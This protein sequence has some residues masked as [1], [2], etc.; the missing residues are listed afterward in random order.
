M[1]IL[2]IKKMVMK[3]KVIEGEVHHIYQKTIDGALIFYSLRDYLVFFTIYCTFAERLDVTVLA[4]CPMPDHLHSACR[5]ISEEQMI[6]FVQQYTRI[7]AK[8]WNRSRKRKGSLFQEHFGSAVK[9]GNKAVRTTLN[10][11]NNNP[12]ERKI[13]TKAEDYRWNFLKYFKNGNP[14]SKPLEESAA[15][16][17]L[18][19]ALNDVRTLHKK[20]DWV[21]YAQLDLWMKGLSPDEI[22][23]L[24]DYIITTWNIIDYAGA[25]CYYGNYD[26]MLRSLHDNTGGEYDIREDSDNYSDAV[27]A[28]CTHIL[29]HDGII[30]SVREIPGLPLH[31]K[32][33]VYKLLSARTTAKP[34]QLR[35]YLHLGESKSS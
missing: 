18:R 31:R 11:N 21:R 29:M 4:L 23:V 12:V 13:T 9:L 30:S 16:A 28:D 14:Y 3:R 5:F 26:A 8:E 19:N 27:Y 15:S 34:K 33:E 17:K 6:K 10:Y 7:F 2:A 24:A 20:G 1:H 35:K 32:F 25:I 22:Q